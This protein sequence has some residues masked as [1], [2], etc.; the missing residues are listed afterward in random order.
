MNKAVLQQ[1]YYSVRFQK[2]GHSWDF[3]SAKLPDIWTI[4]WI[5]F[6]VTMLYNTFLSEFSKFPRTLISLKRAWKMGPQ[7][8]KWEH[9]NWYL[10]ESVGRV[11]SRGLAS[12][13]NVGN[14]T[15]WAK[16]SGFPNGWVLD[17]LNLT[18]LGSHLVKCLLLELFFNLHS[19][20]SFY[21]E[22]QTIGIYNRET[23]P[24]AHLFRPRCL[25]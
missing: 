15:W 5:H 1:C 4:F 22:P 25:T 20:P 19:L 8:V 21:L 6:K 18:V 10:G 2:I 12:R 3:S 16:S 9:G 24:L 14:I 11:G 13:K 17:F 7:I 23:N